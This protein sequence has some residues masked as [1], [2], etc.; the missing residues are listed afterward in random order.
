M[1]PDFVLRYVVTHELVHLVIPDHS[2]RFR[3]TVQSLCP[4]MERAK[5]W[6]FA[7]SHWVLVELAGSL[8]NDRV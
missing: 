2:K 1:A 8:C 5:Q 4:Q 7:N 3:L 6:L